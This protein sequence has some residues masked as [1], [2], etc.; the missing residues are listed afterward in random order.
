MQLLIYGRGSEHLQRMACLSQRVYK[1]LCLQVKR[2]IPLL[3]LKPSSAEV[4][5]RRCE[6]KSVG[7]EFGGST[8]DP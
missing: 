3:L 4:G 7:L 2:I 6:G 8:E 5:G 1:K